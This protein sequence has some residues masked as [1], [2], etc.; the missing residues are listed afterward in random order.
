MKGM[1]VIVK[2][3]ATLIGGFIFLYGFYI[4]F[5]GHLTPGGG[6]AGGV[7]IAGSFILLVLAFGAD[8]VRER[9]SYTFSSIFE[10]LGGILF[11]FVALLGIIT[12]TYFFTNVLPKGLPLKILSAGIIPLANI[13]IGIKVG[14]G[15]LSIFIA[16]AAMHFIMKE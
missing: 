16:L 10:S 9:S 2:T 4:V 14:A 11:L 5:H 8:E 15:L 12:G 7:I 13:A 1:S 6:F 3:I